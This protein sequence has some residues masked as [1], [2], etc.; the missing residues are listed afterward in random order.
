[1]AV[2]V[3]LAILGGELL[4]QRNYGRKDAVRGWPRQPVAPALLTAA[5]VASVLLAAVLVI[6]ASGEAALNRPPNW[7][8]TAAATAAVVLAVLP[9][10]VAAGAVISVIP[11]PKLARKPAAPAPPVPAESVR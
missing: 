5:I 11:V 9:V 8:P 2:S 4:L 1:M 6:T 10:L 7:I 3:L